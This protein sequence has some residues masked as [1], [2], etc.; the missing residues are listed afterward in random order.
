MIRRARRRG[1]PDEENGENEEHA[2]MMRA[3][4]V[5]HGGTVHA[6]RGLDA[7]VI[8]GD[9][10]LAVGRSEELLS[11]VGEDAVRIDLRGRAVLPG[12]IDAHVHL[13]HTGLVES[14]WRIDLTERTRKDVLECL[15]DAARSRGSGEWIIAYG[16]DESGWEDRRYLVRGEL[17]RVSQE[18]PILAIR[19]DGHLLTANSRALKLLPSS[20]P[21]S[22]VDHEPG[23]L[24]E[25][26]VNEMLA[27]IV[28]DRTTAEG[29]LSAAARLCHRLGVTSVHTMSRLRDVP[30]F[31]SRRAE[32]RLRVTICPEVASF[33]KVKAVGFQ[34]GFGDPW[35]RFGGIKIFADGSIG[36]R[37]AAVSEAFV[38]GGTGQLNHEDARLASMIRDAERAGWQTV[39]HAIG[40][41]AIEQVLDAHGAVGTDPAARHRMEHF[42]LPQEGQLARAAK[43]GLCVSMQPN[44]IG[45]WS[46][47]GSLYVDRLGADRDRA[48]NPLRRVV[49]EGLPLAFGSD[50]MPVS[51][52]YGLHWAVNGPYPDQ[53]LTA[54]EAVERYT[55]GGAWFGFEEGV[56]G[57]IEPGM[58]ADLVVLDEDP[59]LR[60]DRIGE[61]TVDMTFV[62]GGRVYEREG[63]V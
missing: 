28:P 33:D 1:A 10:I 16:W 12:F 57:R 6:R 53:R 37:N 38:G 43:L 23:L 60:P 36:A 30:A 25:A 2:L 54:E 47:P 45:N 34:T 31:M 14:G 17:D 41:R 58:L 19:M 40:D 56:K 4:V 9:R 62:G 8:G 52:L 61:R 48:S 59:L 24:R 49:D 32:R 29:A 27:R 13:M 21:E 7:V 35:L 55:A 22:L 42:E 11:H 3:T 26:A 46:G 15:R 51:P 50:G 20:A 44:F 63:A 18:N 5:L 39:I